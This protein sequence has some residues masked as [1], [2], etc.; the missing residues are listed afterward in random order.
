MNTDQ[1]ANAML[2][3]AGVDYGKWVRPFNIAMRRARISNVDRAAMWCAQL[4][5][6]SG[7]LQWMVEI[8]DGS[9]YNGRADL[10]NTQPGDGPR[11]KGRGPIQV[12]GRANY[13]ALSAWAHKHGFVPSANFFVVHPRKLAAPRYVFLGPVWYWTVARPQLNSLS[14]HRDIVGATRAINGGT[15]GLADRQYRWQHCLGLGSALL[16]DP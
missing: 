9:Q 14:D 2:H 5:A 11:F 3:R 12:T 8:S 1:L 16:P 7:G 6:E 13:T 15:N 10:G 4:G